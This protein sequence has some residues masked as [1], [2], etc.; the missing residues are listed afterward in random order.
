M[1]EDKLTQDQR[2]RLE[3]VVQANARTAHRNVFTG[4]FFRLVISIEKYIRD[5]VDLNAAEG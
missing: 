2:I 1:L 5:G 4:D 3:A